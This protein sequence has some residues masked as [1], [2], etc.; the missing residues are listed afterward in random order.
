MLTAFVAVASATS[1]SVSVTPIQKVLQ[2]L[3]EMK[4]KG[5]KEMK[6]EDV[7]F[8]SFKQFCNDTARLKTSSIETAAKELEKLEADIATAESDLTILAK[9]LGELDEDVVRWHKDMKAATD[10]RQKEHADYE[11]TNADY[12]ETLDALDRA[13]QVLKN[14]PRTVPQEMLQTRLR[15]LTGGQAPKQ[16]AKELTA[17]L[18]Q[19]SSTKQEPEELSWKVPEAHAYERQ[20]NGIMGMLQELRTRFRSE[21]TSLEKE[22]MGAHHAYEMIMQKLHDQVDQAEAEID[23]K[24]KLR[25]E[26]Q[27]DKAEAE[28][29]H[30]ETSAQKKEDEKYLSDLQG[31]CEQKGL[32]FESRQKLRSE[33]IAALTKAIEII[34]SETV[35]GAAEEH[36]PSSFLQRDASQP[37][38][39][40]ALA[41]LRAATSANPHVADMVSFLHARATALGS[42]TLEVI[43]EKARDDP[44][45]K[46]KKMIRDLLVKL[47]EEAAAEADH[48]AW[49]DAELATNK[50]TR[51]HKAEAVDQ[52]SAEM[53]RLTANGAK[54]TQEIADLTDGIAELD[55][56]MAEATADRQK[57]KEDNEATIADAK[58]AQVAVAQALAVLRE[59]YAKAAQAT[60][61]LQQS[62]AEDAPETFDAPYRGMQGESGG[63][64]GMIEVIESDFARLQTETET[65]E[66]QAVDSYRQF[67][68]ETEKNKAVKETELGHKKVKKQTND[69]MLES[70][71]GSLSGAQAELEAANAYF[72]KLR[73]SCIDTGVTFEQRVKHREEEL[74]SLKEAYKILSGEDLP[75]LNAMKAEQ[76]VPGV[77]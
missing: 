76:I 33:E 6:D 14:L 35:S 4:S 65:A 62:P 40:V 60:A 45:A 73:P 64:I 49:C 27:V 47:M 57:E 43:A 69:E 18:Q 3:E 34:S 39:G 23:Q 41:Q 72:E 7:R 20:S 16:V 55:Q 59:F 52:L 15:A 77:E 30:K 1:Q 63:V 31:L 12:D 75:T 66:A 51:T 26:R 10:V 25:A 42:K 74:Q 11:A 9:A 54:L 5:I 2:I 21:Q 17:L 24:S 36:L 50:L 44:F 46:V 37:R 38:R 71:K 70:T 48:K 61:L 8:S 13:I 28:G 19:F 53:E 58:E 68:A 67:K 32:D 29:A 22:E 56:A